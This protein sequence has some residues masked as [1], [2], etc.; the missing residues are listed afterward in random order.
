MRL[1]FAL[2]P[3]W[4]FLAFFAFPNLVAFLINA[5][6]DVALIGL[7]T[8]FCVIFSIIANKLFKKEISK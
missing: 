1:K 2:I 3:L 7:V 8:I 6:S 4:I 5:H